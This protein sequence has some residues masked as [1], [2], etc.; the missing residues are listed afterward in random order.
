MFKAKTAYADNYVFVNGNTKSLKDCN[1]DDIAVL[2]G[3]GHRN[4]FVKKTEEIEGGDATGVATEAIVPVIRSG[5]AKKK[6]AKAPK[7]S[8]VVAAE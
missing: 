1:D 3:N 7:V 6:L 8:P 5:A 4:W 2:I